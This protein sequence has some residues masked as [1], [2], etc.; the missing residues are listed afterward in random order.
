MKQYATRAV[1]TNDEK[2][3]NCE[4]KVYELERIVSP[5]K[6]LVFHKECF[7]CNFCRKKL[8]GTNSHTSQV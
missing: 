7:V 2:C 8:D 1:D 3:V 5:R 6:G 4:G